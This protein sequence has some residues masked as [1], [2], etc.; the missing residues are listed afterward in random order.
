LGFEIWGLGF[1]EGLSVFI[2][3]RKILRALCVLRVLCGWILKEESASIRS[4][5]AF[6]VSKSLRPIS[7]PTANTAY[8]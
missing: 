5:S 3:G 2:R 1:A 4:G 6:S 8:G 7:Q